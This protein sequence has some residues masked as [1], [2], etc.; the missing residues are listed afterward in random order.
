M[1]LNWH[2]VYARPDQPLHLDLGCGKGQFL[3]QMAQQTPNWNF[4]GIEIRQPL[5]TQ[6]SHRQA[7]LGLQNLYF[8][9]GN[10]NCSLLKLLQPRAL[11]GVTIQFPDP[12][13]KHRHQ[14]RRL[15]QPQLVAELATCLASGGYLL[16]QS[17]VEAVA[18][19]MRDCFG[20]HPAFVNQGSPDRWLSE[21]PLPAIS[22]RERVTLEKAQPVYRSLFQRR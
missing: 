9:F 7:A 11:Q 5:V 8:L 6:A 2:Q 22:D 13:F 19:E 18:I 20:Q 3:L 1:P 4:L 14:K 21:N 10:A 17:D 16:L 15:V 12:W